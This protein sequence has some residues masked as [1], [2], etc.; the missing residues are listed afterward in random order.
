MSLEKV[1]QALLTAYKTG[2][3][4][5]TYATAYENVAFEAPEGKNWY[6]FFFVPV[7]SRIA[8][9]GPLGMDEEQ[10]F[11]Q[12]DINV[13]RHQGERDLRSLHTKVRTCFPP[14]SSLI[15]DGQSVSL[16]SVSRS[17]GR[18]VDGYFRISSTVRWKAQVPR[19][20]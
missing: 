1:Q 20:V 17:G 9:L 4:S 14:A 15:Y 13:P 7:V 19:T 16:L 12:I 11:V 5:N 2:F 10:G 3:P 18:E 8:T 6:A